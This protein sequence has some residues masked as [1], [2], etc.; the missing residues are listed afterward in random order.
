MPAFLALL[1]HRI[2]HRP[3]YLPDYSFLLLYQLPVRRLHTA[4]IFLWLRQFLP[5]PKLSSPHISW[6]FH[7]FSS[8]S[9]IYPP[10]PTLAVYLFQPAPLKVASAFLNLANPLKIAKL[11]HFPGLPLSP[12]ILFP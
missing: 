8:L 4:H 7:L 10:A 12:P 2:F 9:L 11:H 5:V 3:F 6:Q 1:L